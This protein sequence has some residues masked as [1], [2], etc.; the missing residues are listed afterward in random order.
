M[1]NRGADG[2]HGPG[3]TRYRAQRQRDWRAREKSPPGDLRAWRLELLREKPVHVQAEEVF[4]L[5]AERPKISSPRG[6]VR[7]GYALSSWDE[8][9]DQVNEGATDGVVA[10]ACLEDGFNL[11]ASEDKARLL[12]AYAERPREIRVG[13]MLVPGREHAPHPLG[14]AR[15]PNDRLPVGVDDERAAAWPQDPAQLPQ[16]RLEIGD[17]LIHLRCD[18]DVELAVVERQQGCVTEQKLD[19]IAT[20]RPSEREHALTDVDST[21]TSR[22]ADHVGHFRGHEARPASDV[23]HALARVQSKS[24]DILAPSRNGGGGRVQRL[25][26]TRRLPVELEH[27]RHARRSLTEAWVPETRAPNSAGPARLTETEE[28]VGA[29]E[30]DRVDRCLL[31][32]CCLGAAVGSSWFDYRSGARN[33]VRRRCVRRSSA[34][35]SSE[36]GA[37]RPRQCRRENGLLSRLCCLSPVSV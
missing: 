8:R 22:C 26:P 17:V 28:R 21:D 32:V 9:E 34:R 35:H 5:L 18:R 33:Q 30:R 24:R 29:F 37:R 19:P 16:R 15:M 27:L 20:A 6:R 7:F 2:T 1:V 25:E 10:A 4:A 23:E 31:G 11:A 36:R 12:K 3:K 14:I 13:Q